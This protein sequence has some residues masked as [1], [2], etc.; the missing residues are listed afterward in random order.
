MYFRI[1]IWAA[2]GVGSDS[3][4]SVNA[5]SLSIRPVQTKRR[6]S[7]QSVPLISISVTFSQGSAILWGLYRQLLQRVQIRGQLPPGLTFLKSKKKKPRQKP[8]ER[9]VG[10]ASSI[11]K[12]QSQVIRVCQPICGLQAAWECVSAWSAVA[13]SDSL[14]ACDVLI[15][16]PVAIWRLFSH[17]GSLDKWRAR[18]SEVSKSMVSIFLWREVILQ[19]FSL[20]ED[21]AP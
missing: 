14:G 16:V 17:L 1:W 9:A 7:N 18:G 12:L 13:R 20:D 8:N 19:W 5:I 15:N 11:I 2:A 21:L 10:R 6:Q 4:V 3:L